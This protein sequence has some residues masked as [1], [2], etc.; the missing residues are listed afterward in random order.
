MKFFAFSGSG[1]D[2]LCILEDGA[3]SFFACAAGNLKQ[4][5]DWCEDSLAKR[6]FIKFWC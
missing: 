2:R 4:F 3:W 1:I 5:D 6:S